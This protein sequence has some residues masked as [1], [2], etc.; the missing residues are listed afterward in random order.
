MTAESRKIW[1]EII[2]HKPD[3][4]IWNRQQYNKLLLDNFF[5]P[6]IGSSAAVS[7]CLCSSCGTASSIEIA[8]LYDNQFFIRKIPEGGEIF[9]PNIA[10][11]RNA[12]IK[13]FADCINS[14]R[15]ELQSSPL[16]HRKSVVLL[17][18]N[19]IQRDSTP[20]LMLDLWQRSK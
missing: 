1:Q 19:A 9:P 16:F 11:S 13:A 7:A 18:C 3:L 2:I 5:S 6:K 14:C 20:G 15:Y 10:C 12:P 17:I 4:I 8:S